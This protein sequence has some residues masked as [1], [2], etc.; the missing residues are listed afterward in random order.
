MRRNLWTGLALVAIGLLLAVSLAAGRYVDDSDARGD[1]FVARQLIYL[2]SPGTARLLA[3]GFN[4]LV[5]DW[6]W[7]RAQ[8]YF[9]EP[10]QELNQFRNLGDFLEVVLGVD[11]DFQYVYKFAGISIPYDTGRLHYVNTD[12]AISFLQRGV[13]RFPRNWELRLYLGFYLLNFRGDSAAAAEQ[14]AAAAP[15]PGAPPYLKRFAARLFSVSGEVEQAK[16]FTEHML[17]ITTDPAEQDRLRK[18][19][20]E[21]DLEGHLREV[22]TAA[23]RFR[24]QQGRWPRG[25]KELAEHA[26]L[27][28]LPAQIAL[29]NGKITGAGVNRLVVYEHP[30]EEPMR[31]VK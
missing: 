12:R 6:Y 17:E 4:Q 19:L 11:P 1:S 26:K 16:A 15:L 21:V 24:Q 8:Q 30:T 28:A 13:E 27:P 5:A 25:L 31:A 7:V 18:R 14:L 20:E 10:A 29:E 23:E 9:T 2:P 22:E 3:F